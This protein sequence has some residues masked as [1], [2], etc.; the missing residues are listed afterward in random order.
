MAFATTQD[1]NE[2]ASKWEAVIGLEV[3]V[4]LNTRTK[5]F[6]RT[7]NG[8]V[9]AAPNQSA[10]LVDLAYPGTLPVLN[11]TA[12]THAVK[13]GAAIDGSIAKVCLFD[14]KH[15]FYPDLPKGYQI[16]QY[17]HPIVSSGVFNL[18]NE[19]GQAKAVRIRRVHLEEDAG[20]S[21]HD[22]LPNETVLDFNRAGTPLLEIVTEPDLRTPSEA[23]TCLRQLHALVIWLGLCSGNLNEGA[24]RCDANVSLRHRG[25]NRYGTVCELKNLNS[26]KF[27]KRAL[28]YEIERQVAVLSGGASVQRETRS[29]DP[30]SG[31]TISLRPKEQQEEYRYFPD[32]DL[33]PIPISD[34]F[35]SQI[36]TSMPELPETVR[37]RFVKVYGLA[38]D[39]AY[40]LTL[41]KPLAE[42][43]E[44]TAKLCKDPQLAANWILGEV[45]AIRK[46][47]QPQTP[48]ITITA[49]QLAQLIERVKDGTLSLNTGKELVG[50]LWATDLDLDEIVKTHDITQIS[51]RDQISEWS[52]K[53]VDENQELIP[54]LLDGEEKLYEYF[55]GQ[56]MRLSRGK[57]NPHLVRQALERLVLADE[58]HCSNEND[59]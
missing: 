39:Q 4:Q 31:S 5:L 20:K 52:A 55:I 29:Y 58:K 11:Q 24:I 44:A 8:D 47:T 57:A 18:W 45:I 17:S 49:T 23:A 12:L 9:S 38:T 42:L 50:R 41:E 40:R 19:N 15:Y 53:V 6:S 16:S 37:D 34:E 13:F 27:L 48:K 1:M 26:F 21:I 33:P 22:R 51:D 43:F 36:K 2:V 3:H 28:R 14:R 7:R 56:V 25:S 59:D 46:R 35:T 30:A 32:P 54:K 10:S